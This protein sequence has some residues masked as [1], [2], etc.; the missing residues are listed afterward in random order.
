MAHLD[1]IIK[2][3]GN[4]DSLQK[5]K[6]ITLNEKGGLTSYKLFCNTETIKSLEEDSEEW[7]D[8]IDELYE[9]GGF[10]DTDVKKFKIFE[11]LDKTEPF[12]IYNIIFDEILDDG[13]DFVSCLSK[14]LPDLTFYFVYENNLDGSPMTYGRIKM[15]NGEELPALNGEFPYYL[16]YEDF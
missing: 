13:G 12:I 3:K 16:S 10:V 14:R 8:I 11:Y 5:F 9:L 7:R 6:D 2:V 1:A 15:K 4:K